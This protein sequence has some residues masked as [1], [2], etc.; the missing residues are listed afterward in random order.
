MTVPTSELPFFQQA[1]LITPDIA[2]FDVVEPFL[3]ILPEILDR[4]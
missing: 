3:E 1:D 4:S 2:R